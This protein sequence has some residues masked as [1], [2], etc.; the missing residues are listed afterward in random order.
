LGRRFHRG[1]G[2]C[3]YNGGAWPER[4]NGSHFLSETTMSLVHHEFITLP[5]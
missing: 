3:V 2:S 1:A 4:W 5:E